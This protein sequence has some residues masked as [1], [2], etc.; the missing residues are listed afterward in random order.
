MIDFLI[1]PT[2]LIS[3][4]ESTLE[5]GGQGDAKAEVRPSNG[6]KHWQI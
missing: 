6:P 4:D 1:I 3:T 5:S 2:H